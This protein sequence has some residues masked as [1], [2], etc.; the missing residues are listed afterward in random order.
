MMRLVTLFVITSLLIAGS[1]LLSLGTN[2]QVEV[3]N[4]DSQGRIEVSQRPQNVSCFLIVAL[5]I[6]VLNRL[7]STGQQ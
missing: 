2:T 5:L 6:Q 3:Y 4:L 1:L 7:K